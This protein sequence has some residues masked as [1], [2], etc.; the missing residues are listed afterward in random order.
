VGAGLVVNGQVFRGSSTGAGEIGH[1]IM[2][3]E[4]GALCRCG[5]HGC[6]ETLIAEPVILRQAEA[7]AREE[8]GGLLASYLRQ[9]GD[10]RPID[11]TWRCAPRRYRDTQ[12]G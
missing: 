10:A 7:I 4:N 5:H 2:M 3:P 11:R 9:P 8:P 1:M 6:L 12:N